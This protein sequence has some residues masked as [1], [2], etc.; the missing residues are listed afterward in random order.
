MSN[1][2]KLKEEIAE[3]E[4]NYQQG[5]E[6]LRQGCDCEELLSITA[7][8]LDQKNAELEGITAT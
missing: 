1:I 2:A 6:F 3:L 7:Y 5:M 8:L 4:Q